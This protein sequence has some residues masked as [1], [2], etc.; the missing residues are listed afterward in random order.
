MS[1]QVDRAFRRFKEHGD[2][3]AL[4]KVFDAT[5]DQ[6][7]RLAWHL[8][9][10]RH[11]AEDLVQSTFL[12]AIEDAS[13][14]APN[15]AVLPW[16]CGILT[17]RARMLWRQQRTERNG[18]PG[19]PRATADPS[20]AAA[21]RELSAAARVRLHALPEP[22]RQTCVLHVEHGLA[23]HE[24]ASALTRPDATVRSQLQRGL[25]MLRRAL[26]AALAAGARA[27]CP[28]PAL[29]M[30]RA[31]VVARARQL[32]GV[33]AAPSLATRSPWSLASQRALAGGAAVVA[34]VALGWL[35][36]A[37]PLYGTLPDAPTLDKIAAT[38]EAVGLRA[39]AAVEPRR[40]LAPP[41][42]VEVDPSATLAVRVT[43]EADGAPAAGVVVRFLPTREDSDLLERIAPT[44]EHGVARFA[45]PLPGH[46]TVR[47]E[48]GGDAEVVVRGRGTTLADVIVP[49]GVHVRG[50]VFD[51]DERAVIGARLW[52]SCDPFDLNRGEVVATSAGDGSF[53]IRDVTPGRL[54]SASV[55]GRVA[56][57]VVAVPPVDAQPFAAELLVYEEGPGKVFGRVVDQKGAPIGNAKVLLGVPFGPLSHRS[58][59]PPVPPA[60]L[61]STDDSGRFEFGGLSI[62]DEPLSIR[63][64]A[65]GRSLAQT[66]LTISAAMQVTLVLAQEA[67]VSGTAL[68]RDQE[69]AWRGEVGLYDQE[70]RRIRHRLPRWAK[71]VTA[72]WRDGRF[73]LHN[74]PAGAQTLRAADGDDIAMRTLDLRAGERVIWNAA[75]REFAIV[76]EVV[77][78]HSQPLAGWN[79]WATSESALRLDSITDSHGRF[80]LGG[81]DNASYEVLVTEPA[82]KTEL[83]G[84][85][86]RVADVM[87]G[88][89]TLHIVVPDAQRATARLGARV[90][91]P[92]GWPTCRVQVQL[93]RIAANGAV[94]A[95]GERT[96]LIGDRLHT[97]LLRPGR[98]RVQLTTAE[99]GTLHPEPFDLRP[100]Q[101]LELG[102]LRFAAPGGFEV[103]IES[104]A[105][106]R[107]SYV[108]WRPDVA[109]AGDNTLL[110]ASGG[111][112]RVSIAQPGTHWVINFGE[113][114]AAVRVDVVS[115]ATTRARL[116]VQAGVKRLFCCPANPASTTRW[117]FF[118]AAGLLAGELGFAFTA[119]PEHRVWIRK[120]PPGRYTVEAIDWRGGKTSSTF[121]VSEAAE[122][123]AIILPSPR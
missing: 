119:V 43:W 75:L 101:E 102:T 87:P 33:R 38:T 54:L 114:L 15:R 1:R 49:R 19:E 94:E 80:R 10:D 76:G 8:S 74:L 85:S 81:A 46:A 113:T 103:E 79:V 34:C 92:E 23:A 44:D 96:R 109:E 20:E 42:P 48:R 95:S 82:S 73:E 120:L 112:V 110:R 60:H 55:E 70:L 90:A 106:E 24:I 36:V 118:D 100:G 86:A 47:V 71:A 9:G 13:S 65:A 51:A 30:M 27:A 97:R 104:A 7:F 14:H 45:A 77:D 93:Q 40:E 116:V 56:S 83:A 18:S 4:A 17:N 29:A 88:P 50:H 59:P 78:E 57:D 72:P 11:A 63:A 37:S 3:D 32:E 115:G 58:Q 28:T 117:R 62:D 16:L 39:D 31:R 25:D 98:Y 35:A 69:P 52:L 111:R 123:D 122:G 26:P 91:L 5:A 12:C 107:I 105:K 67:I 99:L 66:T 2:P 64:C 53:A 21:L 22:Y 84:V 41:A 121:E 68:D 6:L 89:A 61:T 108:A